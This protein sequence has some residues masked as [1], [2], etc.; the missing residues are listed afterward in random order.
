MTL[1]GQ[2]PQFRPAEG[3][4]RFPQRVTEVQERADLIR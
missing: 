2:L 3:R 4:G 1:P